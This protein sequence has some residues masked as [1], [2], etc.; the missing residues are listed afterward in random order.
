VGQLG[1]G[2]LV[3]SPAPVS[4]VGL[5]SGV[6]AI[7]GGTYH[8]CAIVNGG[9][10]C[11]GANNLVQLGNGSSVNSSVPVA[12]TGLGSGVAVISGGRAHTCATTTAGRAFCWGW[13][14]SGQVGNGTLTNQPI[15][16]GVSGYTR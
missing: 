2:T 11:W 16:V 6:S 8:T 4:V 10:W 9:A 14:L 15:P 3:D 12:V 7:T 1:D 5:A 13:N